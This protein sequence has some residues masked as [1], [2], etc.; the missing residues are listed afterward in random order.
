MLDSKFLRSEFVDPIEYMFHVVDSDI[1]GPD[2]ELLNQK[3]VDWQC[4]F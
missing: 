4:G 2:F 1:F 3:A